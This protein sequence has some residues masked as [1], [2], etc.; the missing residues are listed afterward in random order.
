MSLQD[1][2]DEIVKELDDQ[3]LRHGASADSDGR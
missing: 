2:F 3:Q 1:A